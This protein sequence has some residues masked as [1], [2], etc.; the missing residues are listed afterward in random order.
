MYV[1]TRSMALTLGGL[2]MA[3]MLPGCI[4]IF[5]EPN[6]TSA[7]WHQPELWYAFPEDGGVGS[8]T[9]ST[10]GRDQEV[11][12]AIRNEDKIREVVGVTIDGD[13]EYSIRAMHT[14]STSGIRNYMEN[15]F[16]A[17]SLPEPTLNRDYE[18]GYNHYTTQGIW[19]QKDVWDQFPSEEQ[20]GDFEIHFHQ[21]LK[22]AFKTE[23]LT[24][25][26]VRVNE[27]GAVN[28]RLSYRGEYDDQGSFSIEKQNTTVWDYMDS[29]FEE[30]S[31]PSPQLNQSHE[32]RYRSWDWP[33]EVRG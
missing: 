25:E 16:D 3:S 12:T 13:V 20:T 5:V 31:L 32:F 29:T 27:T 11:K 30:L 8:Y 33:P 1:R 21:S 7:T 19:N 28:Y 15:M 17:L 23:A 9:V 18:F 10:E 14:L 24:S 6:V 4:D 2:F 26:W 22:V